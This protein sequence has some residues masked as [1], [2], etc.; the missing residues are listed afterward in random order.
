MPHR[1]PGRVEAR[2]AEPEHP[3]PSELKPSKRHA[4]RGF[5][6]RYVNAKGLLEPERGAIR[7]RNL[8]GTAGFWKQSPVSKQFETGLLFFAG[9]EFLR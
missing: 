4:S 9:E 8:S 7:A 6:A 3:I 5:R 1:E 2:R